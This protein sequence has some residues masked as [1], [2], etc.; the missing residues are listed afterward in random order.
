MLKTYIIKIPKTIKSVLFS[1]KYRIFIAIME[2]KKKIKIKFFTSFFILKKQKFLLTNIYLNK[3]IKKKIFICFDSFKTLFKRILKSTFLV[4]LKLKGIGFKFFKIIEIT[5]TTFLK[6]KIGYSHFVFYKIPNNIKIYFLK[7]TY[8]ILSSNSHRLLTDTVN[9]I[10]KFK[11][12]EP[13]KGKGIFY[14][15]EVI[16]LKQTKI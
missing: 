15:D 14:E 3:Y 1:T 2:S 9:N 11:L 4:K 6:L 8:I 7:S 12:K 5:Y 13:Y 10:R 16:K